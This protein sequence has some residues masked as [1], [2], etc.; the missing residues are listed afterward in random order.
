M[1]PPQTSERN[2]YLF[3]LD[4]TLALDPRTKWKVSKLLQEE[5][6]VRLW[7]D[8]HDAIKKLL[9]WETRTIQPLEQ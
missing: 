9:Q 2:S 6:V 1:S 3:L 8:I 7:Q 4:L 5:E